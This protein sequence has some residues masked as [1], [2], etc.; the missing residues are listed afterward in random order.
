[1]IIILGILVFCI[2]MTLM[3]FSLDHSIPF[4][5]MIALV[6]VGFFM[7]LIGTTIG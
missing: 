4:G 1:M 5:V 6:F 2:G 7:C 3:I